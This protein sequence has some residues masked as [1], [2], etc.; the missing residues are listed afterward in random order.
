MKKFLTIII[1]AGILALMVY[2]NPKQK[3]YRN[4]VRQEMV[5]EAQQNKNSL[6]GAIAPIFSGVLSELFTTQTIRK[7]YIFFSV[8]ETRIGDDYYVVLGALNNFLVLQAPKK[9]K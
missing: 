8:F 9:G 7:D 5:A 4:F 1:I 2:T 6:E 3:D